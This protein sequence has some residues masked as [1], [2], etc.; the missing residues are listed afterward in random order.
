VEDRRNRGAITF[1]GKFLL[2]ENK[3]KKS[4][5]TEVEWERPEKTHDSEDGLLAVIGSN[6]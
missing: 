6:G 2:R 1:N 5:G 4:R 3:I